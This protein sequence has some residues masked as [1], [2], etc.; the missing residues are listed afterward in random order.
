M[1]KIFITLFTL[2][3]AFAQTNTTQELNKTIEN[4]S[5]KEQNLSKEELIQK[6]IQEQIKREEKYKQEQ[7]FYMGDEYN[8]DEHKVDKKTLEHI[9]P[10]EPEYDFNMDDVYD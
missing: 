7:K 9:K 3:M 4:N 1:K 10:I 6:A 2:S 8:L 5:T